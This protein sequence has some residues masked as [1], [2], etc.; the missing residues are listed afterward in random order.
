MRLLT[1]ELDRVPDNRSWEGSVSVYVYR[2]TGNQG[3]GKEMEG[4]VVAIQL[5]GILLLEKGSA[6][7]KLFFFERWDL[8][9]RKRMGLL[10]TIS[11]RI[12]AV[13]A[14][15]GSKIGQKMMSAESGAVN[16][17]NK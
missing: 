2:N 16:Q 13:P 10:L 14:I 6:E 9:T 15:V 1:P 3:E 8:K 17:E 12:E 11:N 7:I 4:D 5:P